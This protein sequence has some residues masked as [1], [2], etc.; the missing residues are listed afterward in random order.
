MFTIKVCIVFFLPSTLQLYSKSGCDDV[1]LLQHV[2][3]LL[4]GLSSSVKSQ[5]VEQNQTEP[6][7]DSLEKEYNELYD[8]DE[9]EE[10]EDRTEGMDVS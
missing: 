2:E 5:A 1:D 10:S 9:D 8:T 4:G 6:E 7:Q 3:E